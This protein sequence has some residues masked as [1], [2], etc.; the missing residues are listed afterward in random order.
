V[1]KATVIPQIILGKYILGG[2]QLPILI[3]IVSVIMSFSAF[4]AGILGTSRLVYALGREGTFPKFLGRIHTRF[5]TPYASLL[6]LYFIVLVITVAIFVTRNYSV[7]VIVAAGFDAFM[8]GFVGYSA[9]WH[10]RKMKK[11]DVPFM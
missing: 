8:Y 7:V 9:L 2:T 4:N 5:L 3:G 10:H 6:F 1:L 11:A